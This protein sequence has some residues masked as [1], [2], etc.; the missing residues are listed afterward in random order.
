MTLKRKT[1]LR[2]KTPLR[3]GKKPERIPKGATTIERLL[4]D[5]LVQRAST[6]TAKPKPLKKRGPNNPGWWHIAL[7][8]WDEREHV[9]EVYGTPLG[10]EPLPIYFSHLL[11][12]GSYRKYKLFKPNIVLKSEFAHREWHDQGPERLML[13]PEWQGVCKRYYELKMEANGL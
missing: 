1:P 4:G 3:R 5:K 12:R 6:F 9:C 10:D 8:I 7:E 13:R 2:P 11:P